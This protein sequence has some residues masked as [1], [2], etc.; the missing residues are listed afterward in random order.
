LSPNFYGGFVRKNLGRGSWT[1]ARKWEFFVSH[2]TGQ[3]CAMEG[4]LSTATGTR[5]AIGAHTG[6]GAQYTDTVETGTGADRL[7]HILDT[8]TGNVALA[9]RKAELGHFSLT[10]SGW[11]PSTCGC[12]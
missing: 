7:A 4:G 8:A 1:E 5:Q 12:L 10:T 11:C 9:G 2:G 3:P 6:A